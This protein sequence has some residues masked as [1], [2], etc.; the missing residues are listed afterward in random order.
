MNILRALP[1]LL[2]ILISPAMAQSMSEEREF[3][4]YQDAITYTL[5]DGIMS[6]EEMEKESRYVYH[7]CMRSNM[8]RRYLD[9]ECLSGTFLLTREKV[10]PVVSQHQIIEDML[11]TGKS[12]CANTA[13]IAGEAYQECLDYS[14]SFRELETDGEDFCTCV[15]N[16]AA[17][18]FTAAPYVNPTHVAGVKSR[19]RVY[20]QTTANRA[21]PQTAPGVQPAP[22]KTKIPA[23]TAPEIVQQR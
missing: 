12:K 19:A 5:D 23:F 1:L 2:L 9:C 17:N 18:D 4:T 21:R 22:E 13:A 20:C 16:K 3:S 6:R 7:K 11:H 15:A 10:G 8:M 14:N